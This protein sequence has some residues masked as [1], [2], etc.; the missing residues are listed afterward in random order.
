MPYSV[1]KEEANFSIVEKN[2]APA[3]I[4]LLDRDC[5]VGLWRIHKSACPKH[6]W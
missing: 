3:I 5:I 1:R 4:S 2:S 6:S